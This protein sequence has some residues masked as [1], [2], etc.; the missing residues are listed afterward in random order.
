MFGVIRERLALPQ[1]IAKQ[2]NGDAAAGDKVE[3]EVS[4]ELVLAFSR[5]P[6][7]PKV[8]VQQRLRERQQQVWNWLHTQRGYFYVC[9][10]AK[11]MARAV[12]QALIDMAREA[13]GMSDEQAQKWVKDLRSAGRYQEDVWS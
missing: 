11:N 5:E 7:Q 10:D 12:N 8:Y 13:G 3:H 9:G 4:A 2:V 1:H 6:N